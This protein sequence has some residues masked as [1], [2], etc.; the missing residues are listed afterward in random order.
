MN[1]QPAE[2]IVPV[3]R[4]ELVDSY[5]QAMIDLLDSVSAKLTTAEL[6]ELNKRFSL[7]AEDADVL[8]KDWLASNGF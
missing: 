4:Q 1:L 2:N 3:L 5:G 6:S 8:A 7:D